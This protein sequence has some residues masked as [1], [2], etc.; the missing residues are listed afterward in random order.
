MVEM[1]HRLSSLRVTAW[2]LTYSDHLCCTCIT[3]RLAI[4]KSFLAIVMFF[5][6]IFGTFQG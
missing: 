4:I 2:A 3:H 6:V 1:L 5:H